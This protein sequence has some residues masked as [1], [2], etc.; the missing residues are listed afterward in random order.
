MDGRGNL[1]HSLCY[2]GLNKTLQ[3]SM[4]NGQCT[5]QEV[6][7]PLINLSTFYLGISSC[8]ACMIWKIFVIFFDCVIIPYNIPLLDWNGHRFPKYR[9]MEWYSHSL[10]IH[11]FA[12]FCLLGWMLML[13]QVDAHH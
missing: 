3:R 12:P 7:Y 9:N 10:D 11:T 13:T 4:S 6:L 5:G 1:F 8:G 2:T